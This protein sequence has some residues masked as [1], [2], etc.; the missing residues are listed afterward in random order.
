MS[1]VDL[2]TVSKLLGHSSIRMTMRYAHPTPENFKQAVKVL[3]RN[4][5]LNCFENVSENVSGK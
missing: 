5:T 3:E 1:A 2:V 4:K